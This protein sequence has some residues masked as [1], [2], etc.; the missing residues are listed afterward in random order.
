MIYRVLT[1]FYVGGVVQVSLPRRTVRR[2][3]VV[4]SRTNAEYPVLALYPWKLKVVE[5]CV[6]NSGRRA[7]FVC[8]SH[9]TAHNQNNRNCEKKAI[10]RGA[11][12]IITAQTQASKLPPLS[13]PHPSS[14]APFSRWETRA[15]PV[16]ARHLR[17]TL[18][19][20]AEKRG[21]RIFRLQRHERLRRRRLL[22]SHSDIS[23]S[24]Q[25]PPP[26]LLPPVPEGR[27]R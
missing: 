8:V 23:P 21:E 9:T 11:Q 14:P 24:L 12:S 26:L 22:Q 7:V 19:E 25:R 5:S 13:A 20:S 2:T 27:R 6:A 10:G 4:F 16:R 15:G 3:R 1:E 18:E 17:W